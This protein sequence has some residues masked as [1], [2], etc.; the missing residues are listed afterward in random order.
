MANTSI[1]ALIKLIQLF[2]IKYFK[3]YILGNPFNF[4]KNKA[5]K[6]FTCSA[7]IFIYIKN[8]LIIFFLVIKVVFGSYIDFLNKFFL[9]NH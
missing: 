1:G 8:L 4:D 7:I 9:I 2:S 3:T 6:L 5:R